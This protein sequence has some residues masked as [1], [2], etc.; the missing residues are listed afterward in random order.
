MKKLLA[1]LSTFAVLTG[2]LAVPTFAATEVNTA[3]ET[4]SQVL[5]IQ[6]NLSVKRDGNTSLYTSPFTSYTVEGHGLHVAKIDG[7]WY[8]FADRDARNGDLYEYYNG[9][10]IKRFDVVVR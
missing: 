3:K 2:A 5:K 7:T 1:S 4:N 6:P 8:L 10:Q 9:S